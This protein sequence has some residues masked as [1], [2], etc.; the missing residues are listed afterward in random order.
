MNCLICYMYHYVNN[1][2][3][4]T[5]CKENE[6]LRSKLGVSGE[7]DV[8]AADEPVA[9]VAVNFESAALSADPLQKD[10]R[11]QLAT[12]STSA[13]LITF[14]LTLRLVLIFTLAD[15]Y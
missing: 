4:E 14:L 13:R 8:V 6:A 3:L 1:L 10:Q 9:Q 12:N 5:L 15:F 7:G 2:L 11:L